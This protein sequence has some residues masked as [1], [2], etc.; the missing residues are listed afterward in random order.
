M[1]QPTLPGKAIRQ[2]V[3]DSN[4]VTVAWPSFHLRD[5][6]EVAK[7][8]AAP[9]ETST[10]NLHRAIKSLTKECGWKGGYSGDSA[11]K[12]ANKKTRTDLTPTGLLMEGV[13]T[14]NP[15]TSE[16]AIYRQLCRRA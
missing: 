15:P 16:M 14:H 1:Q 3:T 4:I 11:T 6:R 8:V 13:Y 9:T 2:C 7:Q 5:G 10:P 12:V